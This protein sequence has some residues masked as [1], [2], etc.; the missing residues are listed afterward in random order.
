MLHLPNS[1]MRLYSNGCLITREAA[2]STK[3]LTY[4]QELDGIPSNLPSKDNLTFFKLFNLFFSLFL[5][6][7]KFFLSLN[8]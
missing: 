4:H 2:G 6:T 5:S 1:L 8:L 3:G 7:N